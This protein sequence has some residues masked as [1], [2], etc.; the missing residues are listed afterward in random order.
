MSREKAGDR[1]LICRMSVAL[2]AALVI[3][4][5]TAASQ[6][7]A[8]SL[9]SVAQAQIRNALRGFYFDRARGDWNGLLD[10]MLG[11]KVDANR[12]APFEAI[13]ASDS[14]TRDAPASCLT[15]PPIDQAII[16]IRDNW[17]HISVPRCGTAESTSDQ[18][19]MI[20]LEGKWRFVDFRVLDPA[21]H[22]PASSTSASVSS[23]S[24]AQGTDSAMAASVRQEFL[25]AWRGYKR[26]AWGHDELLPLSRSYHDWYGRSLLMTPVDALDT[27]ILMGLV[28][29]ARE[30]RELIDT[31]LS[32]D[33]DIYVKNFEITIRLLGGLLSGYELSHDKRLLALAEDLGTRLLPA[34]DSPTGMPYVE[35]NL[36]T[37]KVRNPRT[38]PAEVGTL[39]LEL[40]TLSRLTGKPVFYAKAKRA[41]VALYARRSPR[42]LVGSTID[43]ETGAWSDSTSHINGG[44]DSYYEYLLKA[45]LLFGDEDFK[46]MWESSVDAANR[47]LSD[48]VSSGFWYGQANM[49]TGARVGH[50]FEALAAFFPGTLALSGDL[51]R[52]RR[53]QNSTYEMWTTFGVE[54][55]S[56]DYRTMTI[57]DDGYELRPEIIESAYYLYHFTGD[58]RYRQM[59]RTFLR[60]LVACCKTQVG[61]AALTSVRTHAQR[62]VMQSYFLAETL[63]YLYLLFAA[64]GTV[65]LR[66]HVFNTEAHPLAKRS[67]RHRSAPAR[68]REPPL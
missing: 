8:A 39:L 7:P 50:Q 3:S 9:D 42:G 10:G 19:R 14:L 4:A 59:G 23:P 37:G 52:A 64:P 2:A 63:K 40:G 44:I 11:S 22:P 32:F 45:W 48:D 16:E 24:R 55:E 25:H 51:D 58:D 35:V 36:K 47:Y 60:D 18:F 43:V 41:M 29:E 15:T 46:R 49:Y 67:G 13:V 33:Q 21:R 5:G 68:E 54:P 38:N 65:D 57:V 56:I 26:Y 17:A 53:L 27:M 31:T 12:T 1:M 6:Q 20:R 34:F 30:A 61:F 62:D 66:R 28:N